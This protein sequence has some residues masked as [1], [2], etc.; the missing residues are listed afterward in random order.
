MAPTDRPRHAR[1][2]PCWN[3]SVLESLSVLPQWS[4]WLTALGVPVLALTTS[5]RVLCDRGA[6]SAAVDVPITRNN[7]RPAEFFLSL[8]RQLQLGAGTDSSPFHFTVCTATRCNSCGERDL[9]LPQSNLSFANSS[10]VLS[11]AGSCLQAAVNGWSS[12]CKVE[13]PCP[14]PDGNRAT[15][16]HGHQRFRSGSVERRRYLLRPPPVLAISVEQ[17]GSDLLGLPTSLAVPCGLN[18]TAR[19]ELASAILATGSEGHYFCVRRNPQ[20]V[21]GEQAG[22]SW[23]TG[24]DSDLLRKFHLSSAALDEK[25]KKVQVLF[26]TRIDE[27]TRTSDFLLSHS[28][29]A[30]AAHPAALRTWLSLSPSTLARDYAA[31]RTGWAGADVGGRLLRVPPLTEGDSGFRACARTCGCSGTC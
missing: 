15:N 27:P 2:S 9:A 25:G 29:D 24:D 3:G 19:Y 8:I 26:Y 20:P 23:F 30:A 4:T 17:N 5:S 6:A 28:P 10:L 12:E 22:G 13:G 16:A 18:S 7:Y 21:H 14:H 11:L 31:R 1:A